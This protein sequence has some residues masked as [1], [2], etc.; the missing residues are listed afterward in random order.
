MFVK[1]IGKPSQRVTAEAVE[2]K[3]LQKMTTWWVETVLSK[4]PTSHI[5]GPEDWK[6]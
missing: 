4:R 2:N 1:R 3:R 6:R 5:N